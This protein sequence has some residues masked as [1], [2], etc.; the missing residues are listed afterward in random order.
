[1]VLS[2]IFLQQICKEIH[3]FT[4]DLKEIHCNAVYCQVC[5]SRMTDSGSLKKSPPKVLTKCFLYKFIK[6]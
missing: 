4:A 6:G 1:M 3:F 5:L 2:I